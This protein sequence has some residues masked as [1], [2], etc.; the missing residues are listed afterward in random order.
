MS[1]PTLIA[2]A[3]ALLAIPWWPV[4]AQVP[5]PTDH[6]GFDVGTPGRLA[7]WDQLTSYY[8]ALAETSD[9]ITLDTLGPTTA[10][11]PF[12]MLTTTAPEN[13]AELRELQAIQLKLAD[14]RTIDGDAELEALLNRGKTV[15]LITHAIHSTEV[16]SAQ[17]AAR[18]AYTLASSDDP[19]IHEI[20]E[21]VILLHVP[22][23]N[24]DGTQWVNEWYNET[25]GTAY[26][27]RPP[28]WL[29]QFYVGHDNNRD[30]FTFYQKE[31]QYAISEGHN[32]WH[33]Q[34]VHDIHQMGGSGARIFFPPYIDPIE[35]NVDPGIVS[36]VNQ[37]GAWMA[38]DLTADGKQGVVINAIY[39]GYHP[40]RAYQHYHGGARIL[41][42]TASAQ[43]A[44]TVTVPESR[45]RGGREYDAAERSWKFPWPWR[46]GEWSLSHIVD[47]QTSG[48]LALL[49]NAARNRRYWL[50]N[51]Y[52]INRRAVEG[53]D[54]WPGAWVIAAN[55]DN[56]VGVESVIRIL[57]MGD[58][59]VHQA[60]EPFTA[61]GQ[62]FDEGTFVVPMK[63]PYASFAQTLLTVQEYP[64]MR[65][66]P[67]GPPKR[68]Y[69]VT[70]HTLPILMDVQ[71]AALDE[72]PD[73]TLS[74]PVATPEVAYVLP[75]ELTGPDA[76]RVGLYKGWQEPMTAGWTRWMLD[77]H[78]LAYDS[79]HDAR[80]RAGDLGRD[81]DVL[82]FQ[83]QSNASISNGHAP[84]SLPEEYT[85]G[86]GAAGRAAMVE[87]VENG[88][89]LVL[90]EE[91]TELAI[92]LFD[93]GVEN[94]VQGLSSQEFYV[95]GSILNVDLTA[96]PI[97]AGYEGSTPVWY[98]RSS[99]AFDVTDPRVEVLGTYGE[100]NPVASGWIL[101]P[102]HL[103]G[104]PAL[105][106]IR[107]GQGEVIL[108]GFQ[109]NYRAQSI[110]TWPLFFNAIA[111]GRFTG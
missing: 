42:E 27:G 99:R 76:P 32:A 30:W 71:A 40:G 60:M 82:V 81:Y 8:E 20:L 83:S 19:R 72:V 64:D 43:L 37:L 77:Q 56:R 67:G 15:V 17:A 58:V 45:V 63:Q 9:R 89:R 102:E 109:P 36:A 54:S 61:D 105:L 14:P 46:G 6:F 92:D 1:R 11:R 44:T 107:I 100:G 85:G 5:S 39:D 28:P 50:K 111:G 4:H 97:A 2:L 79:L 93:L 98:W 87:F 18:L 49:T 52:E 62:A 84:G 110:V 22:S 66:Y 29:Y 74:G 21:N 91:A 106:R 35:P 26:E 33:P 23:L 88:G 59:E 104:K 41:S 80:F 38:A 3:L 73:V 95:P 78:G 13:H 86:I 24:P 68:P 51:F 47:Y 108:F 65:E 48:A 34:I 10:G 101:G 69:D 12:V 16:G 7:T 94:A 96:D 25:V 70:A 103:A 53:W 55:Q 57:T 75:E 31:T 90:V